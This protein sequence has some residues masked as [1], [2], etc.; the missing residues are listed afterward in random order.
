MEIDFKITRTDKVSGGVIPIE[1]VIKNHYPTSKRNHEL[2]AVDKA[3]N[4]G[5]VILKFEWIH[6]IK[7][8]V[9]QLILYRGKV[10]YK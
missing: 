6:V 5:L 2:I 7:H 1:D 8:D 3:Y 9:M 4:D 10:E